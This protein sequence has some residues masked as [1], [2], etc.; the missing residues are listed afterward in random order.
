MTT[1]VEPCLR[2]SELKPMYILKVLKVF[3]FGTATVKSIVVPEGLPSSMRIKTFHM[4]N[5]PVLVDASNES[6]PAA[7][8]T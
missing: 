4:T 2:D 8:L 7:I 5:I 1:E 6:I 3:V